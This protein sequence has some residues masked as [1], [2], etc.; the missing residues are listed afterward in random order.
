MT[1]EERRFWV[2][3]L[4]E[5]HEGWHCGWKKASKYYKIVR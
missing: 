1:G 4:K 2:F 5:F 3:V